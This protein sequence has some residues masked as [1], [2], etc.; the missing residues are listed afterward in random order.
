MTHSFLL[1][2]VLL[3]FSDP[4]PKLAGNL[5]AVTTTP[6]GSLWLG[7]DEFI[8]IERLQA[9]DH[10]I[11]GQHQA[12][13]VSDFISLVDDESEIDIE[14]MAYSD[15][16]LWLVGSHSV[17]RKQPKGKK[18]KK[19]VQR[20]AT[21]T[22]DANRYLLA[23][24]PVVEGKLNKTAKSMAAGAL[25]PH[26]DNNPLMAA[27]AKDEHIAPFLTIPS[28][29]N[30]L[31]I[32]G[33]AVAGDKIFLGLRG[34]VLRGWAII[35]ELELEEEKSGILSLKALDKDVHYRK[36]FVDLNGLGVRDLC[37]HNEDLLILA[38]STMVLS[39][40]MQIFR[41]KDA[42]DHSNDTIWS[43]D[44]D[45]LSVLFSL[46]LTM[47]SD[48]AEGITL[49]PYLGEDNLLVVYDRP[50]ALRIP[51]EYAVFADIFHLP[52]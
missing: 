38:G 29:D 8:S 25:P 39:G 36:H 50:N 23:R 16:Y 1:N 18:V 12:V 30:G 45:A 14:G 13:P 4:D 34:P 35:L 2:R 37:F 26:Q 47:G 3:Q 48:F 33:L 44:S 51:N 42:L 24:I 43:Q 27:L 9:T 52:T 17:K 21:I 7:S 40:A 20:L 5:S 31:D 15:G 6:D 28:K 11:Y 46:P 19:D 22:S 32:E 49:F 10:C 41:L